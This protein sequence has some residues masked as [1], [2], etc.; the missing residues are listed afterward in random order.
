MPAVLFLCPDGAARGPM[1]EALI[2]HLMPDV[3]AWSAAW[4]PG[5]VRKGARKV[6]RDNGI[7][8][9][10]LR[11]RGLLE[12][13]FREIDLVVLL[14]DEPGCPRLPSSTPVVRIPMLD[15]DAAPASEADETYRDTLDAME[16][17]LPPILHDS[18]PG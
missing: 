9:R 15:P 1:A 12:I 2:R 7:E 18:L 16:R 17:L 3:D 5:H 14:S 10:G 13:D 8:T 4:M 6:L 11:A